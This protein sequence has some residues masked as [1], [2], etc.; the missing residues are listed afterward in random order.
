MSG[1]DSRLVLPD[2]FEAQRDEVIV[3]RPVR[4]I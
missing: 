2:R 1:D 3:E 4:A